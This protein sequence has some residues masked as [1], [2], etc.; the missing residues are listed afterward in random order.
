[1]TINAGATSTRGH[2]TALYAPGA[3]LFLFG[4]DRFDGASPAQAGGAALTFEADGH[5]YTLYSTLPM[6]AGEQPRPVWVRYLG[7]YRP[8][9]HRSA[10]SRDDL[11]S[12]GSGGL[13]AYVGRSLV[14]SP[15]RRYN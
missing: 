14:P 13:D 4:L 1:M 11:P 9:E 12:L 2:V 7:G 8:S 5:S 15:T 6:T 10:I 3:G